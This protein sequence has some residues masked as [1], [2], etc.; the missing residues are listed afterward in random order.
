VANLPYLRPD[1]REGN[2]DLR[3]EPEIA[4]VSGADGLNAIRGLLSDAPRV[5]A[6][7]GAVALEIDPSQVEAV[8]NLARAVLPEARL[9]V[10]RDLAGLDRIVVADRHAGR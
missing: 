10:L 8:V 4:L 2:P 1:Q 6:A 5:L 3:T 9:D 7:D